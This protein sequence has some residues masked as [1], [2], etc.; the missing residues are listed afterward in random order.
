MATCGCGKPTFNGKWH[1]TCSRSCPGPRLRGPGKCGC[2]KPTFNG[3]WNETCSRSCSG[4][5]IADPA[6]PA[7][8]GR[9]GCGKPTYNGKWNETCIRSCPGP[10]IAD[11]AGGAAPA[12][13]DAPAPPA[14]GGQCGCGKPTYN[15][16]WNETCSR[17]CLGPKLPA[18]SVPKCGCGKPT[19]NGQWREYCRKAC[20]GPRLAAPH[21]TSGFIVKL[22]PSSSEYTQIADHFHKTW[23][24]SSTAK[25][26][27]PTIKDI[28][29]VTDDKIRKQFLTCC[30][31]IGDVICHG[32]GTNPG[33]VQ[34]R[35][36]GTSMKCSFAGTPCCDSTCPVCSIIKTGFEMS[37]AINSKGKNR[38]FF[39]CGLYSTSASSSAVRYA[40]VKTKVTGGVFVTLVA[41]G[42]AQVID[43]ASLAS[44]TSLEDQDGPPSG[45]NSR[46]INNPHA[47]KSYA[48]LVGKVGDPLLQCDDE[49]VVFDSAAMMPKYL[50][51]FKS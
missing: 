7:G 29:D 28:W 51:T 27:E 5:K 11:P 23:D 16:K 38:L 40:K 19:W 33:N 50:I 36:H 3:Q 10:K 22:D 30:A 12:P 42:K 32:Y 21:D 45:M 14:G 2:G 13:V 6:G 39:G 15:G 20:P 37:F 4:P 18:P 24:K 41:C 48:Q 8:G 9:C 46:I 25:M 1:E 17:S 47:A 43:G 49:I 26:P 44:D 34:R 31:N 35:F